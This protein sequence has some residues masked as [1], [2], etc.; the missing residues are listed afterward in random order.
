MFV[1]WCASK[2]GILDT[3]VPRYCYCPSGVAIYQSAG[4]YRTRSSGYIPKRGDVIFYISGGEVCHTGIVTSADANTVYT[5][6]GNASDMVTRRSYSSSDTY[7]HGY[8][9]NEGDGSVSSITILRRGSQ[10]E[11]VRQLQNALISKGYSCGAYG[12]DGNFGDGTDNAVRK[13]QADH[14][15]EVDGIVG[16]AT[17]NALGVTYI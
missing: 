14:G 12:A 9:V 6:E 1:S 17:W 11:A 5:V 13:F 10:G 4:R 15:L 16:S 7:I 8:G 2:A 3:I